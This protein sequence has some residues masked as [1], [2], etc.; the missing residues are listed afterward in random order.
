MSEYVPVKAVVEDIVDDTSDIKTFTL[1]PEKKIEYRPGQFL[2]VSLFGV[3]EAPISITSTPSR[4]KLELSIKRVGKLTKE[5]H[6]LDEGDTL[7]IRGPYGNGFPVDELKGRDI[8]FVGGGI[9]LAPLRSLINYVFDNRKDFGRI[10]IL[11]GART[12]GDL[13][14][15]SELEEWKKRDN[16][17]VLLTVDRCVEEDGVWNGE[18]CVVPNLIDKIDFDLSKTTA[19]VCGP[20]VMI[21]YTVKDLLEKGL[22]PED[23]ILTLERHMK[24]GVG[25]CGHCRIGDQYIC[26]DGPVYRY[27][28]LEGNKEYRL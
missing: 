12:P 24:C 4:D 6:K 18:V 8:L 2:E 23:I 27:S 28:Q 5:I 13:V 22:T 26:L 10:T 20:P 1:K 9:G 21:R 19:V 15:R 11:Y 16:T 17:T 25:K 7:W 3:G 14:F